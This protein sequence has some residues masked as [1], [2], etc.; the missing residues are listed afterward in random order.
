MFIGTET[1]SAA[2]NELEPGENLLWTGNPDPQ[3]AMFSTFGLW[4]FAIPWTA[5]SLFWTWGAS[6][7]GRRLSQPGW[8]FELLFP[9]FGLPFILIGFAMLLA[10]FSA[11]RKAKRTTYAITDRRVLVIESGRTKI[12]QS[13]RGNDLGEIK[14]IERAGGSGDL[15][16]AQRTSTDSD[17]DKRTTDTKFIGIA[18][19]RAAD[20]LLRTTFKR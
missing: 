13:F 8:T 6:G 20:D 1:F 14:R 16:F 2:Q 17:G 18:D 15:V 3:R 4:F 10:P 11:S 12:V 5:F 9:L 7:S 19:V